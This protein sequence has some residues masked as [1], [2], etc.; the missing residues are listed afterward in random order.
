MAEKT[1]SQISTEI[2]TQILTNNNNLITGQILQDI[3]IDIAN[4]YLNTIDGDQ[5]SALIKYATDLSGS[6]DNRSLVDKGYV[7]SYVA[8]MITG[9]WTDKGVIDCS[10]NPNYPAASKGWAYKVSVAGKIGGASGLTVQVGDVIYCNADNAGGTQAGVG[11]SWNVLQYNL[12]QAT[13]SLL[14]IAK[15]CSAAQI[16][17]GADDNTIVTPYKLENSKYLDQSG[18]KIY[19]TA[20]GTDTYSVTITPAITAYSAGQLFIIKF[21]NANTG[22]ATLNFNSLG[23]KQL[24]KAAT[25]NLVAGDIK[26]GEIKI[27]AYDGT[28]LQIVSGFDILSAVLTGYSVGGNTAVSSSD[29]ILGAIQKL[30][31]QI[32]YLKSNTVSA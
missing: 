3:L 1:N 25:Q 9:L 6:Y 29:S 5:V 20:T 13:E 8:S 18:S 10:G 24:K 2:L 17:A 14:G 16:A 12:D 26:A 21:T 11:T 31:G 27:V 23:D 22:T 19:A 28:Y 7:T 15:I 4:S 30:Q 32:D